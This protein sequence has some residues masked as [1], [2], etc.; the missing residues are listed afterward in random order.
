MELLLTRH[1]RHFFLDGECE[2]DR[3]LVGKSEQLVTGD[4]KMMRTSSRA[5]SGPHFR[6]RC[7]RRQKVMVGPPKRASPRNS[8]FKSHLPGW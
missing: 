7:A 8:L 5:S 6:T 3:H 2:L 1:G 4:I